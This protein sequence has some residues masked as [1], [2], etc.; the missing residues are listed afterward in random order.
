VSLKVK[1]W[2][3]ATTAVVFS[4]ILSG[5]VL[6]FIFVDSSEKDIMNIM[7]QETKNLSVVYNK[8]F[9]SQIEQQLL[10]TLIELPSENNYGYYYMVDGIGNVLF[11]SDKTRINTNLK[12]IGLEDLFREFVSKENGIY[13]YTYDSSKIVAAFS[14]LKDKNLYLV[15]AIKKS[16]ILKTVD[17]AQGLFTILLLIFSSLLAIVIYFFIGYFI[18]PLVQQTNSVKEFSLNIS[19]S[20]MENSSAAVEVKNVTENTKE[21]YD[22]LDSLI[23]DFATSIEEARAEIENIFG[24]LKNFINDTTTMANKSVQ[25]AGFTDSLNELNERITEISDTISV[26]AIN[27][28]IE[29]SKENIDREGLNRISELITDVSA[30][31]RK[32]AKESRKLLNEIR[33]NISESV[34]I[35]EKISKDTKVTEESLETI[36]SIMDSFVDNINEMTK[37]SH[38]FRYSMEEVLSGV[39]QLMDSINDISSNIEKLVEEMKKLKI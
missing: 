12:K 19:T 39:E 37:L 17:K 34:L 36:R 30:S 9:S 16:D 28:T 3:L 25:I 31:A 35:S 4:F 15:H 18:K 11:H 23:Q 1:Y 8:V 5:V 29:S 33:N 10:E 21:S 2:I 38:N 20:V 6:D 13:E 32:M 14:K 7:L 27:A 24:S 26:L 22:K